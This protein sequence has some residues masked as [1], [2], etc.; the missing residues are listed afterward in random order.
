MAPD[1]S[2]AVRPVVLVYTAISILITIGFKRRR[3]RPGRRLRHRDPVHDGVR[4]RG[5]EHLRRT[6][7]AA[8]GRRRLYRPD[9][10]DAVRAGENVIEKPDGLAI[11]GFFILG[12]VVVSLVSRVSRTTELRVDRIEFDEA[13]RRFVTDTIDFDGRINIIANRPQARDAKEYAEKEAAQRGEQP[14]ARHGRRHVP[15]DRRHGPVRLQRRPHGARGG[16]G[17]SPRPA[18]DQPGRTQRHRRHSVGPARRY[19]SPAA[20]VLRVG[21][22]QPARPT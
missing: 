18:R 21:R 16:G 3:Q 12:I 6:P 2:R 22:G 11:S 10:G 20:R 17:R 4:R 5:R 15:G 14:R 7:E 8:R 1:W 9:P 13:A 19:R